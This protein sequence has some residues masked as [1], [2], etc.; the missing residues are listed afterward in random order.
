MIPST[1]SFLLLATT[2]SCS[3]A[4]QQ[5][6]AEDTGSDTAQRPWDSGNH[7][8]GDTT[9]D[10]SCGPDTAADTGQGSTGP[11]KTP[12]GI[13]TLNLH[14]FKTSETPYTS[15]DD[16]FQAVAE[17]V[18]AEDIAVIAVQEACQTDEM[19]A[20]E[21]LSDDLNAVSD[22]TWTYTWSFSHVGWEGTED[23]A[24][25]GVGVLVRGVLDETST[26]TYTYFTQDS[27]TRVMVGV[28]LP[29]EL[30][31][32]RFFSIHLSNDHQ[33]VRELQG[34][35]TASVA[36]SSSW[37][38]PG[39]LLAGDF[40][41]TEGSATHEAMLD[42]GY[43][44]LSES[45][46]S[47]RIDHIFAQQGQQGT[48]IQVTESKVLFDGTTYDP[49]SDHPGYY[50]RLQAGAVETPVLTHL[51]AQGQLQNGSW[52]S[53]RGSQE[54]LSWDLG[55][56]AW[57]ESSDTWRL[58]LSTMSADTF[59]YKWLSNDSQWQTGENEQG[60]RGQENTASPLF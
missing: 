58:V 56:T 23:E 7:S 42:F 32:F 35:E 18:A 29:P 28:D 33:H 9:G 39:L 55:W 52:L 38:S 34:R 4:H 45:L 43:N 49:V 54:P 57:Q 11:W 40:N 46:D 53:V 37:E 2:L 5:K 22:Q 10:T 27:L 6:P 59:E 26:G 15:N 13:L 24:D 1:A 14:C 41:D 51:V 50:V 12:Y 36:L 48:G 44:D 8:A 30:G 3:D 21:M 25:E 16:R 47:S 31:S 60:L 17:A 20:M 19:S